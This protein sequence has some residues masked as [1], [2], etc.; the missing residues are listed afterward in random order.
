MTVQLCPV[1]GRRWQCS[2]QPRQDPDWGWLLWPGT[3]GCQ[4]RECRT[5][6]CPQLFVRTSY[7][8]PNWLPERLSSVEEGTKCLCVFCLCHGSTTCYPLPR[9]ASLN[10]HNTY[11]C[12]ETLLAPRVWLKENGPVLSF[13]EHVYQ[14]FFSYLSPIISFNYFDN[15]TRQIATVFTLQ[16][17]KLGHRESCS[18]S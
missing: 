12:S 5:Q 9:R 4:G 1:Q 6:L 18:R 13:F 17:K 11:H 15:S 8:A 2:P 3:C 7:K 10:I 16:M 14:V